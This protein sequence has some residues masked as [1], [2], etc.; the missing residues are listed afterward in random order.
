MAKRAYRFAIFLFSGSVFHPVHAS[1]LFM[2][3]PRLSA[4]LFDKKQF[5][6]SALVGG[7]LIAGF[8]AA[9]N[10][11]TSGKKSN[12][13]A[14]M[15]AG[16]VLNLLLEAIIALPVIF[17]FRPLGMKM[18]FLS[19]ILLVGAG[20]ILFTFI[21]AGLLRIKNLDDQVFPGHMCYYGKWQIIPVLLISFAYL[22]VHLGFPMLFAHFPNMVL[23]F[24]LLPHF[25]FYSRIK[26][27]SKAPSFVIVSRY[28]VA[29]MA[30]YMPLVFTLNGILPKGIM[31][32]PMFLAEWYIYTVLYLFLLILG[33]DI[34]GRVI[35]KSR[36][37][38]EAFMRN[39]GTRI[40]GSLLVIMSLFLI[41]S[42]GNK[43]Y[44]RITVNPFDIRIPARD[45][46]IKSLKIC[47]VAD[48]HLN[49]NTSR[50]FLHD[51]F[52]RVTQIDP[53]II[54]YGGDMLEQGQ[55]SKENLADFDK[56]SSLLK[57]RFGK[58]IV[59]GNHDFF[60]TSGY[61]M[62]ADMTF[63]HD[64]VVEVA[65]SFYLMGLSYRSFEE[66]PVAGLKLH[67]TRNLP[68][69][70][71]DHS[72][73]QLKAAVKNHIDLQLS[74]HTHDGQV[75]PVNYITGLLYELQWGYRKIGDSHFFVTSGIQGWGTPIRTA[76]QS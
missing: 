61:N 63:L 10:V 39:P 19:T 64:T 3:E 8:I 46:E 11:W 38:P 59:N 2:S 30:C 9:Y 74:G 68:F 32:A 28:L 1:S 22:V 49:D 62:D 35:L 65:G 47:F 4:K 26:C 67:A 54:L 20:Q 72:P 33:M 43:R 42:E 13:V 71:L 53:D 37:L 48:M 60:R 16:L 45:A 24:Y 55:I 25:Y 75:W 27:I 51:Y 6:I 58:Y 18:G 31:N 17:L 15:F 12:A 57:P 40:A 50:K 21:I 69:F 76:G 23:I 36:L 41:L 29:L 7:P 52:E 73:Y 56:Q 14:M 34:A 66:K 70:L 44:N 5:F